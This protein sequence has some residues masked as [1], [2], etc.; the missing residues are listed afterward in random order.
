VAYDKLI[1]V[2]L[3]ERAINKL[4]QLIPSTYAGSKNAGGAAL[5]TEKIPF[6]NIN[7]NSTSTIFTAT[8]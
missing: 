5:L 4:K 8:V 1:N 7:S 2:S 6:G 3:L